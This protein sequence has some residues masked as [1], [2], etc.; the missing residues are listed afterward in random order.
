MWLWYYNQQ[1]YLVYHLKQHLEMFISDDSLLSLYSSIGEKVEIVHN[2]DW[3]SFLLRVL[4]LWLYK[5]LQLV[6]N[7]T[8][9]INVKQIL[10][11]LFVPFK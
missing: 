8:N 7:E 10:R 2:L 6:F 9:F 3:W 5:S 4:I 1:H 11:Q